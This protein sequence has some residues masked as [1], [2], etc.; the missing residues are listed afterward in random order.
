MDLSRICSFSCTSGILCLKHYHYFEQKNRNN[1]QKCFLVLQVFKISDVHPSEANVLRNH[2]LGIS[3]ANSKE[4]LFNCNVAGFVCVTSVDTKS[5]IVT[6]LSPQPELP[7][8]CL[9]VVSDIQ[10]H[11]EKSSH[12]M[13]GFWP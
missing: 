4:D 8:D 13:D 7:V 5:K 6:I 10:Y 11:Y 3:F 1:T 9:F 12:S 2:L